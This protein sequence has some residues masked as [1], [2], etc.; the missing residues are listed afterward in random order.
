M[1]CCCCW[2]YCG[3]FCEAFADRT[4]RGRSSD[5]YGRSPDVSVSS[6][7]RHPL[8]SPCQSWPVQPCRQCQ[9]L[10]C[11]RIERRLLREARDEPP[12]A[13]DARLRPYARV[14][15]RSAMPLTRK[16]QQ[17][18]PL[19]HNSKAARDCSRAFTANV[20]GRSQQ[21]HYDR[22]ASVFVCSPR[23]H[24][25][26]TMIALRPHSFTGCCSRGTEPSSATNPSGSCRKVSCPCATYAG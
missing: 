16:H 11:L 7:S 21:M 5:Q 23:F 24:S 3:A 4:R 22:F 1:C 20:H 17:A 26:C 15:E 8:F 14:S 18:P 6:R 9:Q 12:V 19:T 13:H 2:L 10:L 25:K